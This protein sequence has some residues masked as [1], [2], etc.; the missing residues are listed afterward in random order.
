MPNNR[1]RLAAQRRSRPSVKAERQAQIVNTFI[2]LVAERGTATVPIDVVAGQAGVAR[3]AIRHFVGNR[4]DLMEQAVIE[5]VARYRE[6][7]DA[8][9]GPDPEPEALVSMLFSD[10]WVHRRP[11]EDRAFDLLVVEA[12]GN[13]EIQALVGGAF[14]HLVDVIGDALTKRCPSAAAEQRK[15]AAYLIVCLSEHNVVLQNLG[16]ETARSLSAETHALDIVAD[17]ANTED[18]M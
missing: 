8:T 4:A 10:E 12:R 15:D 13:P 1:R 6:M 11:V 18:S 7:I 3:T 2:E 9:V 14:A 17:L 5:L 16:F